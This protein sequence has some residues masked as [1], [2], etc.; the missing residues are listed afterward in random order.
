MTSKIKTISLSSAA[1]GAMMIAQPQA[2]QA[3]SLDVTCP[4]IICVEAD[5]VQIED[6]VNTLQTDLNAAEATIAGIPA[7]IDADVAAQAVLT[8][9]EIDADVAAQ[10]ILT[11]AEIDADVAAQAV[12]TTAE[13]DA[14]VAAQ[15]AIQAVTDDAQN[16]EIVANTSA[17]AALDTRVTTNEGNIATNA[18]G[19]AANA[20]DIGDLQDGLAELRTDM[21]QGLAMSNAMDVFAPDPGSNFRLNVGTGFHDGEAAFGITGTGRVG[22]AG[23]T[24]VYFGM[25]GSEGTTAGKA[26][27]SFQW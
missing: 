18:A 27:V 5:M 13:I 21:N 3:Q 19:I 2:A 14:D 15:A 11:T 6:F 23:T 9:A 4:I 7:E 16:I 22:A 25:A 1:I 17:I 26:G 20:A 8:T 24:L 12:L 10:A